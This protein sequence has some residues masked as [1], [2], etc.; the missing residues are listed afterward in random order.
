MSEPIKFNQAEFFSFV[1]FF[2]LMLSPCKIHFAFQWCR[3]WIPD[4]SLSSPDICQAFLLCIFYLHIRGTLKISTP[5]LPLFDAR[6]C[7]FSM[8]VAAFGAL[9]P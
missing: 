8:R 9:F 5:D 1:T 7:S 4:S 6:P 3:A 2:H